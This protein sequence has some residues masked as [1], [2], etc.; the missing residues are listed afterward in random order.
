MVQVIIACYK[1]IQK[2]DNDYQKR[3]YTHYIIWSDI[4]G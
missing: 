4:D 2:L 3:N 1:H